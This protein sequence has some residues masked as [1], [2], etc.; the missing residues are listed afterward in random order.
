M[1]PVVRKNILTLTVE[2]KDKLVLAFQ[3]IKALPAEHHDSFFTIASYHG[4]PGEF[5]CH[6]GD[7][8]FPTW[9]RAYLYRLE[10]ALQNQVPGVAIPYWQEVDSIKAGDPKFVIPTLLTDEN[11]TYAN[12]E[13]VP[14][15]LRSYSLQ[16]AIEDTYSEEGKEDFIYSKPE[17]YATVRFPF[18]GLMT[19][20]YKEK[21]EEHNRE[22][23]SKPI[24]ETTEVLNVNVA[25]WLVN[26]YYITSNGKRLAAGLKYKFARSLSNPSYTAFSNNTSAGLWN[27][28]HIFPVTS[29]ESPHN[30]MHLAIGGIQVPWQDASVVDFANG[31]M[32]DNETAGFDP[33][34]YFHHCFIDYMF[35]NW[36][37][38]HDSTT[39]LFFDTKYLAEEDKDKNLQTALDPF[40][41]PDG[42][43]AMTSQDVADIAN[44]GYSYD[45]LIN[46]T[47]SQG[48]DVVAQAAAASDT[49][50]ARPPRLLISRIDKSKIRGSFVVSTT[51]REDG[52]VK[53]FI[54][55]EPILS[56]YNVEGCGNC[57]DHL[58]VRYRV[59]LVG[60]TAEEAG[61]IKDKG[62]FFIDIHTHDNPR[63]AP[64]GGHFDTAPRVDLEI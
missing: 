47:V 49:A 13:T 45:N 37:K 62:R 44:L 23:G 2:E 43:R 63:G 16:Q 57:S 27:D 4:I 28:D 18:S 29:L 19:P 31:D 60:W 51:V 25:T 22:W 46:T 7:P 59:P 40:V 41:A 55:A 56:R 50:A 12:G 64:P 20:A 32:G 34:F 17:G 36:Q 15:P 24:S 6:H 58:E 48:S 14:N 11:Y 30:G 26:S 10:K 5:F 42:T 1:A 35:W 3:R 9:H 52:V 21:T 38:R 61:R 53:E 33:I 39:T 54:D 8:L